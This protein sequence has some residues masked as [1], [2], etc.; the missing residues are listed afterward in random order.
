MVSTVY[1][2]PLWRSRHQLSSTKRPFLPSP[3]LRSS[4][5]TFPKVLGIRGTIRTDRGDPIFTLGLTRGHYTFVNGQNER[6]RIGESPNMNLYK[7]TPPTSVLVLLPTVIPPGLQSRGTPFR[8]TTQTLPFFTG[9]RRTTKQLDPATVRPRD[10]RGLHTPESR[11][12]GE[13]LLL[14]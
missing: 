9:Q 10:S 8:N 7:G 2:S 3:V 12:I 1:S 4:S 11:Q 5:T 14:T 6:S 13:T